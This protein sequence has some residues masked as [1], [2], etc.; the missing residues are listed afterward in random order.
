MCFGG[1]V[2]SVLI[3]DSL[4][5]QQCHQDV[6]CAFDTFVDFTSAL[7]VYCSNDIVTFKISHIHV[8]DLKQ[9]EFSFIHMS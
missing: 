3:R 1:E 8:I 2:V 9:I 5:S 6:L 4:A 7:R